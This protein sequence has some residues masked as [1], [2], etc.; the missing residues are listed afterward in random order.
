MARA[1]VGRYTTTVKQLA[2]APDIGAQAGGGISKVV[3]RC[4]VLASVW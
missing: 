4:R 3:T 1:P 2:D